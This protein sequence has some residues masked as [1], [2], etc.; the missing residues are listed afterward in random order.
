MF[1]QHSTPTSQESNSLSTN[2]ADFDLII[3]SK[4]KNAIEGQIK[5]TYLKQSF[6]AQIQITAS[7]IEVILQFPFEGIVA[8]T[9]QLQKDQSQEQPFLN[10]GALSKNGYQNILWLQLDII[11]LY[12]LIRLKPNT[13]VDLYRESFAIAKK[14][15][16]S[17]IYGH[18]PLEGPTAPIAANLLT[19]KMKRKHKYTYSNQISLL[20][21]IQQIINTY[22]PYFISPQYAFKKHTSILLN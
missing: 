10:N 15:N 14:E 21:S 17:M 3:K 12:N 9:P 4:T 11:H 2:S 22:P 5:F 8:S 16:D 18:I 7:A 13:V 20:N 19:Q 6:E 1:L